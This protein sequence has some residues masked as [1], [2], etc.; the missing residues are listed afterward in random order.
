MEEWV[1]NLKKIQP[2]LTLPELDKVISEWETPRSGDRFKILKLCFK[3]DEGLEIMKDLL[4]GSKLDIIEGFPTE[5]EEARKK[6]HVSLS[7]HR[8][9]G[10]NLDI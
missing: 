1:K 3:S 2:T 6:I 4:Y 7:R 10:H 8:G 5:L 9:R